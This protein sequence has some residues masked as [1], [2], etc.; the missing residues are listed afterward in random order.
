MKSLHINLQC[1]SFLKYIQNADVFKDVLLLASLV[2]SSDKLE[3]FKRW[4]LRN[5]LKQILN[6]QEIVMIFLVL[7]FGL[8][9]VIC[10]SIWSFHAS[11]QLNLDLLGGTICVPILNTNWTRYGYFLL[12][13]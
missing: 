11:G 9:T 8:E 2:H 3:M 6:I 5:I 1:G 4:Q 7:Y 10:M 12:S 13:R